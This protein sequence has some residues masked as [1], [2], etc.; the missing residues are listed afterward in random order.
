VSSTQAGIDPEGRET[1]HQ[2]A[3]GK[4]SIY[5]IKNIHGLIRFV[6]RIALDNGQSFKELLEKVKGK[7]T[8]TSGT[9]PT[10]L[11]RGM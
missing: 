3:A 1:R 11:F 9:Y 5:T 10:M 4:E 7:T 2:Q 8:K 6:V